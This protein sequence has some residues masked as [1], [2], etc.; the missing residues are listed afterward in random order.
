MNANRADASSRDG[1]RAIAHVAWHSLLWLVVGNSIGVMLAV[2]LLAPA[3]NRWLG[4]WT[5]GRWMIVHMNLALYG[6]ASLPMLA[7]L[8]KVYGADRGPAAAWCR[9]VLWAWSA[10][11]AVASLTWLS[12]ESSGKLFLDWSGYARI[13]FPLAMLALWLLLAASFVRTRKG[14]DHA[15]WFARGAKLLGLAILLAVPL[16][17]YV[18]SGPNGYPPVNPDTGGPTGASQLESSLFVV[19][20]LLMLPF[21][22]TRRKSVR[23][24]AV[25]ASWVVLAAEAVLCIALGRADVSH[26]RPAQF[27]G[28]GSLLIWLPLTPAYYAAFEWRAN[29]RRWRNA[30]LW[31]W[32]ALL[33]SGWIL[34]LPG[35]LDHFK[36]TDG[37]VG[38][39]F[40]AM[41]GFL[42][43]LLIF[44]MVQLLGDDGWIF[45]RT[46]SF[47][48]WNWSVLAYVVIM[49]V[50]GWLEGSEPAFTI[51]LGA[52]R[53]VLYILRLATGVIMLAASLEWLVDASV[54]LREREPVP[55]RAAQE[56][57]A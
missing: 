26:H 19:A 45:T 40:T 6:W 49:M 8:F 4:E 29:T 31:W 39:S 35:V 37:L 10:S 34:F 55:A 13:A 14:A 21:G 25:G 2:L 16:A 52:A 36:F 30:F 41:A 51:S 48:A 46:W 32:A 50:A 57:T 38:H 24:W 20:I 9:P 11:L 56:K 33:V 42:S 22:L 18:A 44:V 1:S 12:G 3:L 17:I 5:Y 47:H 7:F 23:P 43:A 53:N 54:L 15:A 28:L 27:L